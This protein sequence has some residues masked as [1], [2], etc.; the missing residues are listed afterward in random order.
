[1]NLNKAWQIAEQKFGWDR[2]M[3]QRCVAVAKE[4]DVDAQHLG[5]MGLAIGIMGV[6][7]AHDPK[8]IEGELTDALALVAKAEKEYDMEQIVGKGTA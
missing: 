1:M 6:A 2:N 7:K 4:M 3:F 8:E 5:P